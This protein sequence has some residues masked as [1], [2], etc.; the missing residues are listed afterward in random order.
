MDA[1]DTEIVM[2]DKRLTTVLRRLH[3]LQVQL[4]AYG[5]LNVPPHIVIDKQDAE[6]EVAHIRG[7]LRR[8]RPSPVD[9]HT[10]YLGLLTFQ[11][12]DADVFF[13]RDTLTAVMVAKVR[14]ATLLVVIGPSASGKSSVVR[15]GLIPML[16]R[17]ALT[18]SETWR[19][20]T[21]KPGMRP[22]DMLVTE[23]AKLQGANLGGR[24]TISH[25]LFAQERSLLLAA[26]L[27]LDRARGERLVLIVDQFEELWTLAPAEGRARDDWVN[28]QQQLFIQLL[29]DAVRRP[30][31]VSL[32]DPLKD[33][34]VTVILTMRADFLHR[35][36]EHPELARAIGE[37]DVIVGPMSIDELREAVVHPAESAGAGFE[38]GLVDELV[39]HS[40][41]RPGALP[42]L[43]YALLELWKRRAAA[44]TMTWADYKAIGGFTGALEQH[45]DA[46]YLDMDLAAQALCRR[47]LLS[48]IQPG[49]GV[50]DTRR[51]AQIQDLV[52]ES[53]EAAAV[54]S[55][56][57]TLVDARLVTVG[58]G[59]TPE[60]R[61]VE[62]AHEALIAH[63]PRLRTW[64]DTERDKLLAWRRLREDVHQWDAHG[65][66]PSYLYR[67]AAL[68]N[69][70]LLATLIDLGAL[71]H[72]YMDASAVAERATWRGRRMLQALAAALCLALIIF[73]VVFVILDSQRQ[74]QIEV[75]RGFWGPIEGSNFDDIASVLVAAG[76]AD[77]PLYYLG[78]ANIGVG[79]SEDL[80]NW[81]FT[82]R[83]LPEGPPVGNDPNKTVYNITRLA[84]DPLDRRH[85][86]ASV[87]EHGIY[88][89]CDGPADWCLTQGAPGGDQGVLALSLRGDLALA[90]MRP[91]FHLY[92]STD[93]GATWQ[94]Q[95][96]GSLP[97]DEIYA[98][99]MPPGDE[100]AYLGTDS[101]IYR[102]PLP[103]EPDQQWRWERITGLPPSLL[104]VPGT[105]TDQALYIVSTKNEAA[106]SV[107]RLPRDGQPLLLGQVPDQPR[108]LA[109]G[110]STTYALLNTGAVMALS[111]GKD[112]V[113][114]APGDGLA[115]DILALPRAVGGTRLLL[116]SQYGLLEYRLPLAR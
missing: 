107:Y 77:A 57:Q 72:A 56:I 43:Q 66:D 29:L 13:G 10:P 110:E 31:V 108:A 69:A 68:A 23:L 51:R 40:E 73:G 116:G 9:E 67:G 89:S 113:Q 22:V 8:L 98:A 63:W 71:E 94:L 100:V 33:V 21:I 62:L 41:G 52:H 6:R 1:T 50:A 58:V 16:K 38:P 4:A 19:Y 45:A 90:V 37:H 99:V 60:E 17:G 53:N 88:R 114:L 39:E 11:E 93:G 84:V 48:L 86:L 44:G 55:M 74:A 87:L 79:V 28:Q 35:A 2:L 7:E 75:L 104:I 34:P 109:P 83:G 36:A 65:R 18:G 59:A 105:Q 111:P 115:F 95:Q 5:K 102:S 92:A 30:A 112:A 24:L 97:P 3:V 42:L 70:Q 15:A 32:A 49:D 101:G 12:A 14:R 26:L 25:E 96:G 81:T 80:V 64:L 61:T 27:L 20:V 47:V 82:R 85:V 103:S 54:E 91:S 76:D 106:W 78:S 46:L